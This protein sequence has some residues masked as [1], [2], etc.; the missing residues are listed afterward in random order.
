MSKE[1]S[2]EFECVVRDIITHYQEGKKRDEPYAVAYSETIE[3][4]ITFSLKLWNETYDLRKGDVVFLSEVHEKEVILRNGKKTR[5][6]RA[7]YVRA[8]EPTAGHVV[9][10]EVLG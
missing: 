10:S 9:R 6:W 1:Q 7:E 8:K 5:G 4:P 2:K 3:G